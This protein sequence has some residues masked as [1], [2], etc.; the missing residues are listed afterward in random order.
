MHA[1]GWRLWLFFGLVWGLAGGC[2]GVPPAPNHPRTYP[3][4]ARRSSGA[5]YDDEDEPG[6]LQDWL[7]GRKRGSR[8]P[9]EH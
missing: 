2:S 7:T 9:E 1:H 4:D 5:G 6:W 3:D 8:M